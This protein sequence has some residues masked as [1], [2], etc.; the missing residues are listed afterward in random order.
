MSQP[1]LRQR[2]QALARRLGLNAAQADEVESLVE[3]AVEELT[4]PPPPVGT[5]VEFTL[6]NLPSAAVA[7]MT[8]ST[9]SGG[10]PDVERPDG[11]PLPSVTDGELGRYRLQGELGRGG[12][13]EVLRVLDPALNRS[14]AMKIIKADL[15][16]R[17]DVVARFTEEAQATAQLAHP[18]VVPVHELGLLPDGRLYFTMEEI[19][20]FT[21]RDGLRDL[22][23][24]DLDF[25]QSLLPATNPNAVTLWRLLEAF[26]RVCE[27]IAYAHSRGVLHRDLKPTNVMIGDFG[28]VYV[29]DWGI[30]KVLK[31]ADGDSGVQT[32]RSARGA[33]L[34]RKGQVLGTP[35]YMAPEQANGLIDKLGPHTDVYSLGVILF[36]VFMGRRPDWGVLDPTLRVDA[37][38]LATGEE[39]EPVMPRPVRDIIRKALAFDVE[40]RYATASELG[41]AVERWMAGA[42]VDAPA[43][44][45]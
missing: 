45:G 4:K 33:H 2:L 35:K 41:L 36:E 32:D 42:R 17:A 28:V 3:D 9:W 22:H 31:S 38:A 37:D 13:G 24:R 21:L 12:M 14:V 25:R 27:T 29:L 26:R 40:L 6:E 10:A 8:R 15:I 43:E 19:Q 5:P 7:Q 23:D 44:L 30:A 18:G 39:H 20:G 34:T 16:T 1:D 11:S